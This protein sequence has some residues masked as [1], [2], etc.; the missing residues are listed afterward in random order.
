MLN[1]DPAPLADT[2]RLP[3]PD[4]S[5]KLTP[6][7]LRQMKLSTSL[8]GFDKA[9]VTSLMLEAADGYEQA[10]RENERLRADIARLEATL[11]QYRELEGGLK[12]TLLSANKVAD[13]LRESATNEA[14]RIVREAEGRAELQI[15]RAQ[16]RVEDAQREVDALGLKRREAEVGVE[17]IVSTLQHTLDFIREQDRRDRGHDNVLAHRPRIEVAG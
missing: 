1:P 4:R 3:S 9:E 7:D 5:L 6:L 17:A 15:Q 10:L 14:A 13:D 2:R 12:S 8:R 16:A 11:A